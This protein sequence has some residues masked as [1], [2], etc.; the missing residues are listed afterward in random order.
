VTDARWIACHDC[1]LL[2]QSVDL[3]EGGVARCPR[4]GGVLYREKRDSLDRTLA[5][6]I[7]GLL[8]YVV[9]N[10][11][12]FLSFEMQG[13]VTQTTLASGV[14]ELYASGRPLIAGLVFVTAIGAP[15]LQIGLLLY[16]LLP[17]KLE[18]RP[19]QLPRAFRLLNHVHPWSMM[20]IFLLGVLVSL[21]KLASMANMVPGLALWSFALLILVLAGAVASLDPRVVW[22]HVEITR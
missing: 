12:P 1:D 19:W 5:L 3:P 16:V 14:W 20:E 21:V 10:T 11:F 9:A 7:A 6:A 4:C 13:N 22:R 17:L 18:R 8:L 15:L 2:Q